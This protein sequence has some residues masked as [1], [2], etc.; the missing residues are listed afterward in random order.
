MKERS[1][2]HW[3]RAMRLGGEELPP[4]VLARE[5]WGSDFMAAYTLE[6]LSFLV[7]R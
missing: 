4:L 1:E 5:E 2:E 7:A 6:R 3:S